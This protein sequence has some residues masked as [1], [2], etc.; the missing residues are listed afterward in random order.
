VEYQRSGAKPFYFTEGY[1]ENEHSTTLLHWQSQSMIAHL[2]GALL[3]QIFGNCPIWN[4][5]ASS[6]TSFCGVART[7]ED[8]LKLAG[9][10]SQANIG[11]LMRSRAW[12]RL[13]PD[14]TN[15][16]CN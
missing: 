5:K 2:G 14:Y 9:S 4:F 13:V 7:W 10:V 11:K 6:A 15:G 16:S 1:Y 12:T 3:G 8:S